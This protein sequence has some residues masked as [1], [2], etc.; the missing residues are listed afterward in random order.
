MMMNITFV[1]V[2]WVVVVPCGS[3]NPSK[4]FRLEL[5]IY[6]SSQVFR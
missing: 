1:L 5:A 2:S 3:R 6:T 4:P